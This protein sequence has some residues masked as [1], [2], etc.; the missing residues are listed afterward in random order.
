[1]NWTTGFLI[2]KYVLVVMKTF[3]AKAFKKVAV[4]KT[5]NGVQH[6]VCDLCK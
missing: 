3:V 2:A 6:L 4:S 1:M 5:T